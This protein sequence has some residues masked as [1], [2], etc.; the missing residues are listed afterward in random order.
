VVSGGRH[1]SIDVAAELGLAIAS[2]W[3]AVG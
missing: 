2:V 1:R 3:E